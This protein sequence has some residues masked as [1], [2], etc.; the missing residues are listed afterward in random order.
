MMMSTMT[1][2][3]ISIGQTLICLMFGDRE[4]LLSLPPYARAREASPS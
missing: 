4:S 1:I 2:S 3:V